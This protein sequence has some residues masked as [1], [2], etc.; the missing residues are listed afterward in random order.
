MTVT[1]RTVLRSYRALTNGAVSDPLRPADLCSR[2]QLAE[3]TLQA[4]RLA[5]HLD[6]LEATARAAQPE[7]DRVFGWASFSM[8]TGLTAAQEDFVACWSPQDVLSHCHG[9]REL[10]SRLQTWLSAHQDP[11][12]LDLALALVRTFSDGLPE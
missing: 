11:E 10:L 5:T 2:S 1:P 9:Q 12:D 3:F 6:R 8:D 7:A 4:T